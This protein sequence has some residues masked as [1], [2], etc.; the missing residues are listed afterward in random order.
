MIYRPKGKLELL[1]LAFKYILFLSVV[2]LVFIALQWVLYFLDYS[3]QAHRRNLADLNSTPL[4]K[5]LEPQIAYRGTHIVVYGRGFGTEKNNNIR[6]MTSG[7]EIVPNSW[8]DSKII[9]TIPLHLDAGE[10]NLWIERRNPTVEGGVSFKSN[11]VKLLLLPIT[12]EFTKNDD[13]YFFHLKTI[14]EEALILNGYNPK[15]Y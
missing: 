1:V 10:T 2:L 14:G 4:I 3:Q 9:F 15:D 5:K 11:P 6:L 12:E 13:K 7:K 8:S